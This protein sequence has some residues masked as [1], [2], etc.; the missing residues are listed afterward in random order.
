MS[1]SG[2]EFGPIF[3]PG[4]NEG[5]DGSSMEKAKWVVGS[6]P[7]EPYF[8]CKPP[9]PDWIRCNLNEALLY[10]D[11]AVRVFDPPTGRRVKFDWQ[12]KGRPNFQAFAHQYWNIT[13]EEEAAVARHDRTNDE[14]LGEGEFK[15][16]VKENEDLKLIFIRCRRGA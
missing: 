14:D 4:A 1:A 12:G 9:G 11:M 5:G 2:N 15:G 13:L 16:S 8:V 7:T 6:D 10:D 3:P